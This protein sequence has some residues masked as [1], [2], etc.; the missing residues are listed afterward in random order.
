MCSLRSLHF[1]GPCEMIY[2]IAIESLKHELRV[3]VNLISNALKYTPGPGSV[4]ITARQKE[5]PDN[6]ISGLTKIEIVRIHFTL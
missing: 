4:T 5:M 2:R 6:G 1:E 3:L